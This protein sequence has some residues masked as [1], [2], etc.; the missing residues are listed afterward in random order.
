MPRIPVYT[1]SGQ[2]TGGPVSPEA[3][4]IAFNP[5]AGLGTV[6]QGIGNVGDV[7]QGIADKKARDIATTWANDAVN[8]YK[9]ESESFLQDGEN[10]NNVNVASDYTTWSQQKLKEIAKDAPS[11]EAARIFQIASSDAFTS[12]F[13]SAKG[14]GARSMLVVA[15]KASRDSI[16]SIVNNNRVANVRDP[17]EAARGLEADYQR[18][19]NWIESTYGKEAPNIAANLR[20]DAAKNVALGVADTNPEFSRKIVEQSKDLQESTK[21]AIYSHI[22]SVEL[23]RNKLVSV[24]FERRLDNQLAVA[25]VNLTPTQM[26]SHQEFVAVYGKE[27]AE[28]NEAKY[29]LEFKAT[30]DASAWYAKHADKNAT[31]QE[32]KLK[33]LVSSSITGDLSAK[34]VA[35]RVAKSAHEQA[36]DLGGWLMEN[37]ND[38]KQ[39]MDMAE[40]AID[41][42]EKSA[43]M[44]N[45]MDAMLKYQ[46]VPPSGVSEEEA[47][48]YFNIPTGFKA[49][50]SD[51]Q[52]RQWALQ[53][54]GAPPQQKSQLID[55][56]YKT[57]GRHSDYAWKD[58]ERVPGNNG[59][60]MELQVAN[61]IDSETVRAHVL[62]AIANPKILS[63]IDDKKRSEYTAELVGNNKLNMFMQWKLG[64]NFQ[65]APEAS[66][67][68][69]MVMSYAEALSLE[70]GIKAKAAIQQSVDRIVSQNIHLVSVLGSVLAIPVRNGDL[71]RTD[72]DASLIRDAATG[73]M[74]NFPVANVNWALVGLDSN[75]TDND[76][77]AL[78]RSQGKVVAEPN[79][80]AAS[81]Y[82]N[83][84]TGPAVQLTD[85]NGQPF[86]WKF[87]DLLAIE[88]AK[89]K[90]LQEGA[91]KTI[92]YNRQP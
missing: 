78:V 29:A 55:Q 4:P 63:G 49:V 68:R 62:G 60:T 85:M 73:L 56:F 31:Y 59:I 88:K 52:A 3:S 75:F 16:A 36:N 22:D 50:L 6:A 21:Q 54:N 37:N 2:L 86:I 77:R 76:K 69:S 70:G 43:I 10:Q 84:L 81:V 19:L 18:Q 57:Y 44:D 7:A 23:V 33:E 47:A 92:L 87:D 17:S 53:M 1:A 32:Q 90:T 45:A 14:Q 89:Q 25:Q 8:R 61:L 11:K 15:D 40:A 71:W 28:V 38:V 72:A 67:V 13:A 27:R 26:P 66:A 82:L 42:F 35:Q 58:L 83:T 12:K 91:Q 24:E 30:N 64:D 46:G 34:L 79:G 20:A 5:V 9:N 51:A 41:P 65:G 48:K 39:L 80:Q 74:S